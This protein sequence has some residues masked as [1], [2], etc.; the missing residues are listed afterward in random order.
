L[1]NERTRWRSQIIEAPIEPERPLIDAHHHL[2]DMPGN[3]Y[4]AADFLQD[5]AEH[6]VRQTVFIECMAGYRQSEDETLRPVGETEFVV[7]ATPAIAKGAAVAT[8]IIGFADLSLGAGVLPVLKAHR[9]AA[10][11]RFRG[12]RHSCTWDASDDVPNSHSKPPPSLYLR[13]DFREGF[14]Q[15]ERQGLQF[16]AWCY[17]TQLSELASL[18]R[19]F[20]RT[21]I[22]LDHLGGPLG[23]GGYANDS[24][25]VFE[26]WRHGIDELAACPNIVIKLGG[27]CMP[28]NGFGWH[29]RKT[30]PGS[31]ELMEAL[32]PWF[33][34]CI[35]KFGIERCLFESNFPVDKISCSYTVLWNA[36]KR[37]A[38]SYSAVDQ[39][40]LLHDN[41]LRIYDLQ[42]R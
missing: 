22:V 2:W 6:N 33:S 15:I 24:C 27:L 25:A 39:D 20:P 31:V 23:I 17:H 19:A 32:Q 36:F 5:A 14:A 29:Q 37:I 11:H 34:Y 9:E 16:E 26:Q 1:R 21:S 41:A 42:R 8:G 12:I 30:P 40:A 38:V 18:A 13:D 10:P 35:D 4:L 7:A 28:L 3:R